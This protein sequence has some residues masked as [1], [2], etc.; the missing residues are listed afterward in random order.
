MVISDLVIISIDQHFPKRPK[1]SD[2]AI[3]VHNR[4][5]FFVSR[6][7]YKNYYVSQALRGIWYSIYPSKEKMYTEAF[8]DLS[9]SEQSKQ[10]YVRLQRRW[11]DTVCRLINYY[12]ESSPHHLVAIMF[13]IDYPDKEV[14]HNL[15]TLDEYIS[16]LLNGG[17]RF[18]E[19]YFVAV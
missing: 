2:V 18:D 8:C 11:V 1:L 19:L 5:C 6:Q 14:I 12:A 15:C 17:I 3:Q 4:N 9:I 10:M 13:R 16:D 7:Y